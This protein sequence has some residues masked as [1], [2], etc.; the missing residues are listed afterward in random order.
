MAMAVSYTVNNKTMIRNII[1]QLYLFLQPFLGFGQS[2]SA[3]EVA[4]LPEG[5][6]ECSGMCFIAPNALVMINDSGNDAELFICDTLGQLLMQPKL[7]GLPNRDWE[8]L[9]F[10]DGLLYIGDF[11]N[12]S[13]KREDLEILVLDLSKLLSEEQ[14]S[15]KG[16]VQF[17]YPEQKQFPP[18]EESD[19]YYDLEAMVVSGDSIYLFT[20]NRTKPFDGLVKVYALS[21]ENKS[22]E[23]QLIKEFKTNIGLKHFN[24]VSGASLGPNGDD[25]FLLGYS[26]VWYVANWREADLNAPY[27]YSL[28]YFSQKEA[29]AVNGNQLYFAEEKNK[30]YEPFLRKTSVELFLNR[31]QQLADEAIVLDTNT[32]RSGDSISLHFRDP[33]Y[34]LGTR[35]VL[36]NTAGNEVFDGKLNESQLK[37]GN[38]DIEIGQ[39][40]AGRYILSFDGKMKKA[41]VLS[42]L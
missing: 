30:G 31:Y 4:V 28:G 10:K 35:Y 19:W 26:K 24:W 14:W 8:S 1:V 2:L 18:E 13:N 11:G 32:F 6:D 15:L 38:L 7:L 5:L 20:K 27:A 42:I 21:T 36:Y 12:N 29:I 22:Q 33:H 23:A 41:F 16:R 9:A 40:P 25:L 39:L 37:N 34:F 17:Q 3:D